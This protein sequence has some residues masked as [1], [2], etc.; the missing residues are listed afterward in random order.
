M[1]RV[2]MLV[3]SLL[4]ALPAA[5]LVTYAIGRS[6]A[7][8]QQLALERVVRSQINAQVRERCESDPTWFL[9]GPLEGRPAGGVFVETSPDQ[10]PP[11]PKV[12]AQPFEL[13]AYD[14]SFVGSSSGSARFPPDFKRALRS[15][16]VPVFAPYETSQGTGVQMAMT[17][18][19]RGGPC[20]YFLGRMEPPPNQSR[21]RVL[22]FLGLYLLSALVAALALAQTVFRIRRQAADARAA[23]ERGYKAMAPEQRKDELSSMTFVYNDI[24]NEL[25]ERKARIDDQDAAL[26]RITQST[27][28]EIARPLADLEAGLAALATGRVSPADA[29][30]QLRRAHD[31]AAVVENLSA[32]TKLRLAGASFG[33][34]RVDINELVTRV[35][36]RH[37]PIADVAGV[38]MRAVLP[39]PAI[40]IET[41]EALV[42]RAIANVIDNAIRYNRAGGEV[43][44]RLERASSEPR[45][46]L[47]VTDNGPGVTDDEFR[48]LTAVR[49]FRGDES[50]N[51]RPGAPG[52]GLALAREVADR[53]GMTLDLKRPAAGGFEVEFA[54]PVSSSD[55]Q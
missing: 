54:G 6:R 31:L 55:V 1:L 20:M 14:E 45:F 16:S 35:I 38:T 41:D 40:V 12:V 34:A 47:F 42:A 10:L 27:D 8:D 17:T 49:R 36:E 33:S 39:L 21:Q 13:F 30:I 51:R 37:R 19:W 53:L 24:S 22:T 4:V 7:A 44:V 46:R 11:R 50:R 9:T 26:R 32:A 28:D 18:G 29:V 3:T 25:Q 23:V 48:G 5:L 2:R 52:L 43:V 15:D